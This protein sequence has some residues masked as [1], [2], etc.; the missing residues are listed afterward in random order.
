M[1]FVYVSTC[2]ISCLN[3]ELYHVL[4]WIYFSQLIWL[5]HVEYIAT[6]RSHCTIWYDIINFSYFQ[7]GKS[8]GAPPSVWN[9]ACMCS[10]RGIN[11]CWC[12]N[13]KRESTKSAN[14]YVYMYAYKTV[15]KIDTHLFC[16]FFKLSS[17]LV[18]R[19]RVTLTSMSRPAH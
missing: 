4:D 13:H 8:Q 16:V 14:N 11:S 1:H 15:Q 6:C 19:A 10:T 2:V 17:S 12:R 9:P 18:R 7:G 5:I 3:F